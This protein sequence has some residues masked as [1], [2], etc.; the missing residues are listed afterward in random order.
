MTG[1]LPGAVQK[2]SFR[3]LAHLSWFIQN[4]CSKIRRRDPITGVGKLFESRL[5]F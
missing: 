2:L 5:D 3:I 1:P 4:E